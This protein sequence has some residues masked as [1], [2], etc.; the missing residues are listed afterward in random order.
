MNEHLT[1]IERMPELPA[2]EQQLSAQYM[3]D[4]KHSLNIITTRLA[5]TEAILN[6]QRLLELRELE[7]LG[8]KAEKLEKT[9][10]KLVKAIGDVRKW[11]KKETKERKLFRRRVYKLMKTYQGQNIPSNQLRTDNNLTDESDSDDSDSGYSMLPV[12]FPQR[13]R[14]SKKRKRSSNG[15][16]SKLEDGSIFEHQKNINTVTDL[17]MEHFYIENNV[18]EVS[19]ALRKY[20]SRRNFIVTYFKLSM[21]EAEAQD[22]ESVKFKEV[23]A[24]LEEFKAF[25]GYITLNQLNTLLE[26][27][28][29]SENSTSKV[30]GRGTTEAIR[31]YLKATF[32][33]PEYTERQQKMEVTSGPKWGKQ[34]RVTLS[35]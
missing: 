33:S 2:T 3:R 16:K 29:T 32:E 30:Y 13:R 14:S 19:E 10:E 27:I 9:K 25:K 15:A 34:A 11:M 1:N 6:N 7:E 17:M 21:E 22:R 18:V 23:A 4:I 35:R 28:G 31:N 12:D 24:E 5:N 26:K 20:K 8:E